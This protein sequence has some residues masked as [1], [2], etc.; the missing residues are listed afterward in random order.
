M[1]VRIVQLSINSPCAFFHSSQRPAK[2]NGSRNDGVVATVSAR[3]LI[4][5]YPMPGS[6]AQDGTSPHCMIESLRTGSPASW[7]MVTTGC[8]GAMLYRGTQSSSPETVPKYSST[9]CF[10]RDSLYLPHMGLIISDSVSA[11][12]SPRSARTAGSPAMM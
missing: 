9:S 6:F 3:A 4:V 7:R 5:L 12:E 11:R 8:E 1:V 2:A 10:L